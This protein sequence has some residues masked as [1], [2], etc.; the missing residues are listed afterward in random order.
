MRGALEER[1]C[2][3][4]ARKAGVDFG[5]Q[6][7]AVGLKVRARWVGKRWGRAGEL[8]DV[9]AEGFGEGMRPAEVCGCSSRPASA[10]STISLR[11]V[12]ELMVLAKADC[13]RVPELMG[14]PLEM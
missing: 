1:G 5:M 2:S 10:S 14:S 8:V 7:F 6:S 9:E 13:A 12:A 4:E 11:M 3:G